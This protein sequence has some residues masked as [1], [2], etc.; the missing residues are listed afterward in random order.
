MMISG[1]QL[2]LFIFL[3]ITL[4]ASCFK[5]FDHGLEPSGIG[6]QLFKRRLVTFL[7]AYNLGKISRFF[8][9]LRLDFELLGLD[10]PGKALFTFSFFLKRL[11]QAFQPLQPV[12]VILEKSSVMIEDRS[13][14]AA[15]FKDFRYGP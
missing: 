8:G 7:L 2:F 13:H 5:P 14:I 15:V 11:L 12:L 3:S 9:L 6:L 1:D 4:S 10:L